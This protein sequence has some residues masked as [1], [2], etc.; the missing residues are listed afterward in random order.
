MLKYRLQQGLK[1]AFTKADSTTQAQEK[2]TQEQEKAEF[3][4]KTMDFIQ[5]IFREFGLKE[6]MI[7]GAEDSSII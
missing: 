2:P 7:P 1:D 4:P 6:V 3:A 5:F